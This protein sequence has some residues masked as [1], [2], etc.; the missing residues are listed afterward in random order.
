MINF[1]AVLQWSISILHPQQS[2]RKKGCRQPPH[3]PMHADTVCDYLRTTET[4]FVSFRFVWTSLLSLLR[5]TK[6]CL[7]VGAWQVFL[8]CE[9]AHSNRIS[10]GKAT[11]NF[12]YLH[13]IEAAHKRTQHCLSRCFCFSLRNH[14]SDVSLRATDPELPLPWEEEPHHCLYQAYTSRLRGWLQVS[15]LHS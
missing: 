3:K 2:L 15:V 12:L 6:L 11:L 10:C 8:E 7:N 4:Y 1:V 13:K 14:N 5:I 9:M